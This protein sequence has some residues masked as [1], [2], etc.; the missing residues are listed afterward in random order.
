MALV[1]KI[2]F[3]WSLELCEKTKKRQK[4]IIFDLETGNK[5]TTSVLFP[6]SLS[7]HVETRGN[8][9]KT[10]WSDCID[11]YMT[12]NGRKSMKIEG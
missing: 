3:L 12:E 4:A 5:L 9:M 6:C 10:N 1:D 8:K 11:G 7:N 2:T